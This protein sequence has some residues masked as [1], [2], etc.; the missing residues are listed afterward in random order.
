LGR[1]AICILV[2]DK[3]GWEIT[4]AFWHRDVNGVLRQGAR[5]IVVVEW[6]LRSDVF[7]KA[8]CL[9]GTISNPGDVVVVIVNFTVSRR[10]NLRGADPQR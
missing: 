2:S 7:E 1:F 5:I 8:F 3:R 9:G 6:N 10:R 4:E